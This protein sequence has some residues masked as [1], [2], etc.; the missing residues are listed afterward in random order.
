MEIRKINIEE[1]EKVMEIINDAKAFLK[2]QSQQWQQGYP[3]HDSMSK[4]I[5]NGNLYGVYINE[6]LS[7]VAALII[8]VEKTYVNMIEGEWLIDVSSKDLVIHRIAVS[9]KFRGK[10]CAKKIM[11]FAH[12]LAIKNNCLSIKVD[13]HRANI[14]M[15]KL[16]LKSGYSYRGI[17]DLNRNEEDQLR[18]AYELVI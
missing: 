2:P 3:N 10:G 16:V 13:T 17:I 5:F 6:E 15:Q 18:L 7:C 12:K 11:D 4:D 8:G 9:N 1:L 14:P